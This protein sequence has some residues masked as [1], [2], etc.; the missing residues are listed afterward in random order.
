MSLPSPSSG[1]I[2]A[3]PLTPAET[4]KLVCLCEEVARAS[5]Y[6]NAPS[7]APEE[8]LPLDY[9]TVAKRCEEVRHHVEGEK[10]RNVR[11]ARVRAQPSQLLAAAALK[12]CQRS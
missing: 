4:A 6:A 12:L 9:L 5:H 3:C 2:E 8:R 11:D 10:R 1:F 7:K